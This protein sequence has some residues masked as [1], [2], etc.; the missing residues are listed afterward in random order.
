MNDSILMWSHY[1]DYH[2]GIVLKV[3]VLRD[4]HSTLSDARRVIYDSNPITF[5][6]TQEWI[7]ECIGTG[8]LDEIKIANEYIYHKNEVWGYEKEWRVWREV[9]EKVKPEF[10]DYDLF[11]EEIE[12]VYF[13]CRTSKEAR[14]RIIKMA[15]DVNSEVVFFQAEKAQDR[16]GIVFHRI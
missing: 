3:K 2:K 4:R 5:F 10:T 13:G 16:F 1:A 14:S 9:T 12:A 8:L 7:N 11:P 15:R 6:T